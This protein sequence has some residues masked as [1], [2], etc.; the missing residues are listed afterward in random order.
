[1]KS[2][3][4]KILLVLVFLGLAAFAY[5][6]YYP[7]FFPKPCAKPVDFSIGELDSQFG[8]SEQDYINAI[9]E[10]KAIWEKPAGKTLFEYSD[11][12]PLKMNLVY[13]SR[14][15]AM[16]K[17][18][19]LGF[20]IESTKS[21]YNQLDTTY[22]NLLADYGSKKSDLD[23]LISSYNTLKAKYD[24]EVADFNAHRGS[25]NQYQHLQAEYNELNSM[26]SEINTKKTSINS[27]VDTINA[28][29]NTLNQLAGELNLNVKAYN[30]VGQST[31]SE[32]EEGVYI[33]DNSG[34]YINIYEFG[35]RAELVRVLAHEL[36]HA[37]GFEHVDDPG[38][39]MYKL[40]QS[41]NETP[42]AADI[43]EL[44]S[45]CHL[46]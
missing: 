11:T 45:V 14:Q 33:S 28:M 1:M 5:E 36:G 20:N 16:D 37:L 3:L 35:D 26:A 12:G 24:T 39:I 19:T 18:K 27:E 4:S 15:Q 17:L 10:A 2:I 25:Q 6:R 34:Q 22:K 38:A 29:A 21:S 32:F 40:N 30:Q 23:N 13:D 31:G 46:K 8:L 43:A 42:T 41:K 7:Q 44:N 9:D